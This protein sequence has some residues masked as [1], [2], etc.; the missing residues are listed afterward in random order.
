LGQTVEEKEMEVGI[1]GK[2]E[3]AIPKLSEGV[4]FL[5]VQ[6]EKFAKVLRIVKH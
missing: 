3:I 6:T 2:Y 1:S 5:E 4:Y